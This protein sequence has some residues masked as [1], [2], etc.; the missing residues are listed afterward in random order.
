MHAMVNLCLKGVGGER[1]EIRI[2]FVFMSWHPTTLINIPFWIA[3]VTCGNEERGVSY[4]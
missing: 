3:C 2:V 4:K 1:S